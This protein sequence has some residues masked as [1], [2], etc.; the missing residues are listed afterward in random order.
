M[1]F[2]EA[3]FDEYV[4]SD[5]DENDVKN[6][7]IQVNGK[8]EKTP[9]K[10]N[11]ENSCRPSVNEPSVDLS[12]RAN[13]MIF[14]PFRPGQKHSALEEFP[15]SVIEITIHKPFADLSQRRLPAAL[16]EKRDKLIEE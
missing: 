13:S 3:E 15:K 6:I 5:D 8:K 10:N 9:L 12:N 1:D 14:K 7:E 4:P 2:N 11:G 16:K